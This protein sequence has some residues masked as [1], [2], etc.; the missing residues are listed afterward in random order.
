MGVGFH[1]LCLLSLC[2]FEKNFQTL[3]V[4]GR[5]ES[6]INKNHP[7]LRDESKECLDEKYS[8]NLLKN[9]LKLSKIDRENTRD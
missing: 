3:G 7:L 2:K 5:Q 4:L 8:D 9:H 1:E 6:Y